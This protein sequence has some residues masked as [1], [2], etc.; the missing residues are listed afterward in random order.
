MAKEIIAPGSDPDED[1]DHYIDRIKQQNH[2]D[3]D[4]LS[5]AVKM[6]GMDWTPNIATRSAKRSRRC[7]S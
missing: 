7:S 6:Q 5:E 1:I 4:Q 3:D 2:I